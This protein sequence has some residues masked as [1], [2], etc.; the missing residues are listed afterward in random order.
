LAAGLA[1]APAGWLVWKVRSD[2]VPNAPAEA[3]VLKIVYRPALRWAAHQVLFGRYVDRTQPSK[4]RFTRDQADRILTRAW[5][6][7]DELAPDA[8]LD[9][10]KTLIG[11]QNTLLS[12]FSLALY[13]ALMQEGVERKYATELFTDVFWKVYERWFAFATALPRFVARRVT[14][15]PQQQVNL[16]WRAVAGLLVRRPD[17]EMEIRPTGDAL[18][19]D[20]YRCPM[21]EYFKSQG[22]EEFML[23][24]ICTLDFALGQTL[25]KGGHYERPHTLSAGDRL[26]DM[27]WYAA[28]AGARSRSLVEGNGEDAL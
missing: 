18:A 12:V 24:S 11:R 26:C 13:R 2:K 25:A 21:Y 7:Y 3:T 5:Q 22:E 6:N 8:H 20:F 1:L 28:L 9:R 15:D 23:N 19:M 27:K 10:R 14:N 17:Y 16:M 4:G